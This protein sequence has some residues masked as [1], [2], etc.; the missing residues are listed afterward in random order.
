M[1]IS[2]EKAEKAISQLEMLKKQINMDVAELK[3]QKAT[4]LVWFV[5][6][7]DQMIDIGKVRLAEIEE[8]IEFLESI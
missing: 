1:V 4:G 6:S 7:N 3:S 2:R 8:S 5:E